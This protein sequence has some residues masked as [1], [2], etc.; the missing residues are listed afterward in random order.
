MEREAR[1]RADENVAKELRNLR[2]VVRNIQT[3]KG[4]EGLEYED[5]CI[6]PDIEL[7]AGYKV[8][9]FDMFD[10]KGNPQAHLRSYCNKLVEVG[11]D[12]AIRMKLFIRSLTGETLDWYTCQDPQKWHSWGEMAQEFMDRFRFNTETVPD[13]FYLIKL[14]RKSTKTFREYAM[15]WRAE[16]AKVQPPMAENEMMMLFVQSLKDDTYYERLLSAIGKS[17][18]KSSEWETS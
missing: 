13:R 1:A 12:R 18:L 8:P 2:E 14:E 5:L 6:H 16:A 7:P 3:N 11:K 17:F 15:R 10:G 4:C 9:K